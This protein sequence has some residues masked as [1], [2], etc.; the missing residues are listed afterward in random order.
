MKSAVLTALRTLE[1][2]D[3]PRPAPGPGEVLLKI[4]A[5]GLCGSDVHYWENGRIGNQAVAFPAVLGHE[6]SGIVEAAGPG[7]RLAPG[8]RVMVEPAISCGYCVFCLA[9]RPN[10]CPAVKFLGTPPH[11]GVFSQYHVMP[12]HCCVPIPDSM[13][14]VEAALMEPLAVGLHGVKLARMV[15]G[16][17]AA[18]FGCG[19]IGLATA[20]GA[21]LAGASELFMT[22]PI[23]ERRA[24]AEK[25]A[26]A[27]VFDP[28]S[29][30][31]VA[32]IK[33]RTEALGV[34]L[35]FECAGTQ[36]TLDQS[37][38]AARCG[39]RVLLTGIPAADKMLLP[40]HECRRRELELLHVRR[41]NGEAA[42]ALRLL[43]S[44]RLDVKPL[45]THFFPL[46]RTAE[47]F[48]LAS[49]KADGVIRAM[50]F[51]NGPME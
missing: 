33:R 41:S 39:G 32:W 36:E 15:P 48:D 49:R 12:G 35:S 6:P 29:G 5:V 11:D 10:I 3:R 14:L 8:A 22:D 44:G 27:A 9:G 23:P 28:A 13:S 24:M 37:C 25:L 43:A 46:E 1:I 51:P 50:I 7:A 21:R 31:P 17:R 4:A 20:L 34:E 16:D 26:G 38:L 40:M 47:A 19:P 30:D 42:A 18:I 45:A 2:Q